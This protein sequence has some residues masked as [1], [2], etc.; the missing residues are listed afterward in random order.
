MLD[1]HEYD[2]MGCESHA[3]SE[4]WMGDER[5]GAPAAMQV[6]DV[7]DELET[8][9]GEER[10]AEQ[11]MS[12]D[13]MCAFDEHASLGNEDSVASSLLPLSHSGIQRLSED[14]HC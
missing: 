2:A 12:S 7:G 3:L 4:G 13:W 10:W 11:V 6:E 8:S 5:S 9:A 14:I 1:A